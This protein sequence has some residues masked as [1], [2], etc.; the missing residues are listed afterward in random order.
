MQQQMISETSPLLAL[1]PPNLILCDYCDMPASYDVGEPEHNEE[2]AICEACLEVMS[3]I[4]RR[5]TSVAV[6]FDRRFVV[7]FSDDPIVRE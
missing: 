1:L 2:Y 5:R 7:E 3:G 4:D 6:E